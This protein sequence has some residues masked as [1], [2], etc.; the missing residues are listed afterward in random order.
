[1]LQIHID[2]KKNRNK[3]LTAAA[4]LTL[5]FNAQA[6]KNVGSGAGIVPVD[7]EDPARSVAT[8]CAPAKAKTDLDINNVR[9][10]IMTGGDMWW[11]LVNGRYFVP[12]PAAGSTGPSSLFAGSLWIGGYDAGGQL[13]AAGMTYRQ[14]G[15]DFWPGPLDGSGIT[16][17]T[18]CD[19]WDKHFKINRKDV[20]TYY[21]WFV[22][23]QVGANPTPVTAM[24][25]INNWP[26]V[27]TDGQPLAP[28]Y[29]MIPNG[30]YEPQL[31]EVPDFDITGTRGCAAKLFGDQNMFWVFND[32]GNIHSETGGQ[33]IG[34][35]IQAQAFAFATND[36]IN[37]QTFYRYRIVNK[38]SFRL[39]S[40]FFGV[41]VDADLGGAYDDYVGCDVS[42]GLG[43][44]YNGD[45]VDDN[46]GTGQLL[47]GVNP[48]A[49]GVD[50]FEGPY[51]DANSIDDPASS[52][53]ASFLGY[54]NGTIDDE[55]IGMKKFMY[56]NN[57][58]TTT[59]NPNGDNNFY[60]YLS[61]TWLDDTPMTYGGDG[62]QSGGVACSYMFPGASDP[63]GY[64][65]NLIPQAPWDEASVGN[66]PAD[67]RFLQSAGPFTLQPGAVNTITTGVVWARAN[68]GGNLASLALLKGADAKAQKL[69]DRCFKTL[70][71]PTA[72]NLTIQELNNELILYWT[73]PTNL[74]Q[75]NNANEAYTEDDNP[76]SGADSLY[77]FQ[78]YLIYQ[79][80]DATVSATELY[81]PDRARLVF[82]CDKK[83]GY[84]QIVNYSM[85]DNLGALV[86]QEMVNGADQGIVH[87]ISIKEDK[88]AAGDPK[89]VNHKSYY[90]AI[91]AYGFSVQ[92]STLPFNPA[93]LQD[94][95]PFIAGRK[96]A[97]G[98]FV[99]S[100]IPHAPSPEAGGTVQN[101][102][103]GSGPKLTRIQGQ[104]NGGMELD[105]TSGTI[106]K[107]FEGSGTS[108]VFNP[109][110]ENAKGPV[111]IKVIDPLAVPN[112]EFAIRFYDSTS[113]TNYNV[114]SITSGSKWYMVKLPGGIDDTVWSERTIAIPNE[115]IITKWGISVNAVYTYDP[116]NASANNNGFITATMEFSDPSKRWL[117]ALPDGESPSITN[118]I[119]SGTNTDPADQVDYAGID[120]N[121][122]Y[123][124]VLSGTWAPYRLCAST[125]ATIVDYTSGPAWNKF[126]TLSNLNRVASVDVVF[127]SDKSK[128]TRCPVLEEQDETALALGGTPKLHMRSSASVD[129][130]GKKAGDPGYN[131]ADGDFGGTQPTGMGWFPGYAINLETGERLNMAFGEDSWLIHENGA[132]M[133]WNPTPTL[134][135]GN[136]PVFGGKHYIYVLG[137]NNNDIYSGA[138]AQLPSGFRDI[139]AYDQGVASYKLLKAAANTTGTTSEGYKREFFADAMW[140]NIPLGVDRHPTLETDVK[141]RLR[142]AKGYKKFGTGTYLADG[143][144]VPGRSYHVENGP[145]VHNGATVIE[146]N[147]FQAVNANYTSSIANPLVM[148]TEEVINGLSK[149]F[150]ADPYY[151][152]S[153]ADIQTVVDD[154]DAAVNALDL[155]NIVP[156]PY[157][158]YSGYEKTTLDNLVKITNLPE[159]C[160]VTIYTLNGTLI[161]KFK[162]DDTK[163]SLDWDLKNQARIP[164]ASGLYI[165]HV[166]VPNVGE[167]VLKWFG[168][169]RPID[170]ESY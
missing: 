29:D 51:A 76:S 1:M 83:D 6:E 141:V 25:M 2:M 45:L 103:Y 128:W 121:Q 156:N 7:T 163:T 37:N 34:I 35:E 57:D 122:A 168:V 109:Q 3:L 84:K 123:E 125:P 64:G 16:D 151:T 53:P 114:N 147:S 63:T 82:Q 15:N 144:L 111:N 13:K 39:D 140:V 92:P 43:F 30:I 108:K 104:G 79:L 61:G 27:G 161:R 22:G 134:F 36:E 133:K 73:N 11:D 135:D 20:E 113:T 89:L 87:S 97:D 162:K 157:Y 86:P 102:N 50:F 26:T 167:K 80:K 158:A 138:D 78:G 110:Y 48:P 98:Y 119:R 8:L 56:Y 152:F 49:I 60:Q 12:K 14:T 154:N 44:C 77:R 124:K 166:D 38:S 95:L 19:L 106:A 146:G 81:D 137:H 70:D 10:T 71:G 41:W 139:P 142:V 120:D 54:G 100:G 24:D 126:I 159:Q 59:G 62:H 101:V 115:Q 33:S 31:G 170:L 105:F 40:T 107:F 68:Q 145:I 136:L 4:F 52:V 65:T 46:G 118:W 5:V 32:K 165:I 155:I 148:E 143:Q 9:T 88:F 58:N 90:Y 127:T 55:R 85:D 47:Y 74:A 132:D 21:S 69:F 99:H 28:F 94:Y 164:I 75:S 42:L 117:T 23:G 130:E 67:R 72:P 18:T 149:D 131:S 91:I 112:A 17:A 116:G 160:T 150:N 129:K 96:Q 93:A 66:T 169:M 153:T